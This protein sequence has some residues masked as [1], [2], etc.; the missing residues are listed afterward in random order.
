L[1]YSGYLEQCSQLLTLFKQSTSDYI[2]CFYL[3][4]QR[5]VEEA[6]HAFN[7]ESN[8]V[9]SEVDAIRIDLLASGFRNQ[10]TQ[11]RM[12]SSS[13]IWNNG[14]NFQLLGS[15]YLTYTLARL[16]LLF[17][18]TQIYI[19][20]LGLHSSP[21]AKTELRP[22]I[23]PSRNSW[24]QSLERSESIIR[25][26]QATRE[27]L[28]HFLALPS[29]NICHITTPEFLHLI[30]AVLI[31]GSLATTCHTPSL[32]NAHIHVF[33]NFE[34][35]IHALSRKTVQA[36]AATNMSCIT[37][38]HMINLRHIWQQSKPWYA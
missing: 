15:S 29:E 31:L 16:Q 27:Y 11:L 8:P 14:K 20:E 33:A 7:Y 25:C 22:D 24:Y 35:Y 23:T 1:R 38:Q 18:H 37:H 21:A 9:L 17:Y 28:D 30:Y 34:Y 32:D 12:G 3:Q 19:N 5:I 2:L 6:N 13:E 10:M 36:I 26:L 4:L